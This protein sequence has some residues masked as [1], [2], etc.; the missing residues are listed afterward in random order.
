M[1]NIGLLGAKKDF[2]Q[3]FHSEVS[4]KRKSVNTQGQQMDTQVKKVLGQKEQGLILMAR[5]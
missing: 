4:V 5:G 3:N 1:F 2:K